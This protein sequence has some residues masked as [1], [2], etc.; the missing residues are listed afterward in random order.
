MLFTYRCNWNTISGLLLHHTD[1]QLGQ[2]FLHNTHMC[3]TQ[4]ALA[5]VL[6][7]VQGW[8]LGRWFIYG[9][10]LGLVWG[11]CSW[12]FLWG[13]CG[14]GLDLGFCGR[15]FICRCGLT[16]DGVGVGWFD[17]GTSSGM[18]IAALSCSCE[19]CPIRSSVRPGWISAMSITS[20]CKK[21]LLACSTL[22]WKKLTVVTSDQISLY[23][24]SQLL[25]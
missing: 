18:G 8:R 6:L 4:I 23:T 9:S 12:W 5:L 1:S 16:K 24:K 2:T 17:A 19:S 13:N 22:L 14:C 15:W 11:C 20:F 25:L 3:N 21:S 7:V 10:R